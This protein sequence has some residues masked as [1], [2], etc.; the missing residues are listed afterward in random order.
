MEKDPS[1]GF[2]TGETRQEGTPEETPLSERE[3]LIQEIEGMIETL[4][5]VR[6]RATKLRLSES[7]PRHLS[8]TLEK[9]AQH[10]YELQ[11]EKWPPRPKYVPPTPTSQAEEQSILPTKKKGNGSRNGNNGNNGHVSTGR[12]GV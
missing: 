8:I 3:L 10:V 9:L 11:P 1:T 4:D 12:L 7:I 2:D 5:D 6:R